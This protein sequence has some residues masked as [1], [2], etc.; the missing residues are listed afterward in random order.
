MPEALRGG[1]QDA[2]ATPAC[3]DASSKPLAEAGLLISLMFLL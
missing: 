1:G 3:I 2:M